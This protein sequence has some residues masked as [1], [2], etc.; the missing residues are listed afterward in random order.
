MPPILQQIASVL[1][2]QFSI[3]FPIQVILNQL[4]SEEI[5]RKFALGL[6]WLVVLY[7]VFRWAWRNGLKQYSAVGA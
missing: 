4:S 5:V 6:F 3:Y 2:F 7:G 1:P